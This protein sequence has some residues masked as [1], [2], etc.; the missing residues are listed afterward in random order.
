MNT[1][2]TTITAVPDIAGP[3]PHSTDDGKLYF[4][5]EMAEMFDVT[6]RTLRFYEEKGLL[7]PVRRGSRRFYREHEIGRMQVILQAKRIGLTLVE[8][9]QVLKLVEGKG[10]RAEQLKN[11][12]SICASQLDLLEEQTET[13]RQ[14][15]A[16]T[17]QIVAD[18]DALVASEAL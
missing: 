6:L 12:R 7:N 11:L 9:R 4:I 13:V 15:L 1:I 14:Q 5:S 8:I 17:K 16:E 2:P 18:P 3:I 10:V